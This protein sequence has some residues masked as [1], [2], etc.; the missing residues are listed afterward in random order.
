MTGGVGSGLDMHVE[1]GGDG[2]LRDAI[3]E[4]SL[5]AVTDGSF[6]RQISLFG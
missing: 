2:W 6:I 1:E 3:E 5:V 4:N